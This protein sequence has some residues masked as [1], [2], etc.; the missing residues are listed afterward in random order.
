MAHANAGGGNAV[1]GGGDAVA[2]GGGVCR[3]E[4]ELG[5]RVRRCLTT[6][7]FMQAA[8]RQPSGESVC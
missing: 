6:A 1:G 3:I 7:F 4:A 8:E 5:R 2:V